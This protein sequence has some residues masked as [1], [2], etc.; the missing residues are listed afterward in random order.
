VAV[1][2]LSGAWI[3]AVLQTSYPHGVLRRVLLDAFAG[4]LVSPRSS[5]GA[6]GRL[7]R[8]LY[9][10]LEMLQRRGR[11]AQSEGIVRPVAPEA[12][13]S[14]GSVLPALGPVLRRRLFLALLAEDGAPGDGP[15]LQAARREFL[16]GAV[17]AGWTPAQGAEALGL[18]PA[19]AAA[20]LAA[21]PPRAGR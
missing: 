16:A 13:A 2:R 19:Q 7:A 9:A 6:K 12:A 17:E 10:R 21:P 1:G 11:I 8:R 4:M 20:I 14:R 15:R 5:R 3:L 18:A